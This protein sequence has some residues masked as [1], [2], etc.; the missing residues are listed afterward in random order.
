M[1]QMILYTEF[2]LPIKFSTSDI[3]PP[4]EKTIKGDSILKFYLLMSDFKIS[5]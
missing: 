4:H 5:S 1:Y 2:Q 3:Y